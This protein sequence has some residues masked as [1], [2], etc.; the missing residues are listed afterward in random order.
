MKKVLSFALVL[1]MILGSVSMA[2]AG[3]YAYPDTKGIDAEEAINVLT[4]LGVLEGYS[5]GTFKPEK[6]VTRAEMVKMIIAALNM[7]VKE[8]TYS[9]QFVDVAPTAWYSAYVSYGV[10]LGIIEG[11]SATIFD[12]NG[13]VTYDQAITMTMR[14]LGYTEAALNGTYPACFVS[15]AVSLGAMKNLHSGSGEANRADCAQLIFNVLQQHIGKVGNNNIWVAFGSGEAGIDA[16][17][18]MLVRLGAHLGSADGGELVT[19]DMVDDEDTLCDLSSLLGHVITYYHNDEHQIVA[20]AEVLTK[21]VVGKLNDAET[22]IGDVKVAANCDPTDAETFINGYE[23]DFTVKTGVEYTWTYME[24]SGKVDEVVSVLDWVVTADKKMT[25]DDVKTITDEDAPSILEVAFKVVDEDA[26]EMEIDTKSFILEGVDSLEDIAKDHV[27]YVYEGGVDADD[28]HVVKIQVG[29][30]VVSGVYD[31]VASNGKKVTVED[32]TYSI[33]NVR[34]LEN[35]IAA[36]DV[37]QWAKA[38]NE[39]SVYLDFF[40]K[41]YALKDV[42]D[43]ETGYVVVLKTQKV[44]NEDTT[45]DPDSIDNTV[46]KIKVF[47][48]D[49]E[50]KIYNVNVNKV[51]TKAAND[52]DY[53]EWDDVEG[54]AGMVVKLVLD[55]NDK[56]TGI[57]AVALEEFTDEDVNKKGVTESKAY[58]LQDS[59]VVFAFEDDTKMTKESNWSVVKAT[60]LWN[61]TVEV[62]NC[63][64]DSKGKIKVAVVSDANANDGDVSYG[65]IKS[66]SEIKDYAKVAV[67]LDGEA[68]TV[69]WDEDDADRA[70]LN[71]PGTVLYAIELDDTEVVS[72][73][74]FVGDNAKTFVTDEITGTAVTVDDVNRLWVKVNGENVWFSLADE[75]VVYVYDQS[76]KAWTVKTASYMDGLKANKYVSFVL[77]DTNKED[78]EFYNVIVLVKE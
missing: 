1:A 59:A 70:L 36:A 38:G 17:D 71:A 48:A 44:D 45:G 58:L 55:K 65:I 16:Y 10:T 8:G 7:P 56:V 25:A 18:T 64:A 14:A 6:T 73:N 29:T 3:G 42:E 13:I 26:D 57:K 28:M 41:F 15:K 23:A 21:E 11:K 51:D 72:I 27:V 2:F 66:Y 53:L 60:S 19:R 68:T 62:L 4:G 47:T 32:T 61:K 50:A 74:K 69:K 30:K 34:D 76:D 22:K 77:Y 52:Q 37:N 67:L 63:N 46:N 20:V 43:P 24:K 5:D 75:V 40:G 33:A 35:V 39:G 49:G 12:P 9:T 54:D 31:E 78:K